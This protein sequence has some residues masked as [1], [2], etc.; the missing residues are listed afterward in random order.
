MLRFWISLWAAKATLWLFKKTGHERDDRPGLLA[1]KLCGRFLEKVH[2]PPL[3]IVVTGTNGKTTTS[4]LLNDLLTR[5]GKTVAYNTWGANYQAGQARCLLDAVDVFNR[6]VKDAAV[7]EADEL[8]TH[9]TLPWIRPNYLVVT[10]IERDSVRR[11]AHQEYIFRRIRRGIAEVPDTVLVLNADDPIG[12]FLA[13]GFGGA[14]KP[15]P[16]RRI[17]FGIA[18]QHLPHGDAVSPDFPVCP[19]C[20]T[21]PVFAYRHYRDIGVFSCP[22]CSLHSHTPDYLGDSLDFSARAM[23]VREPG[24]EIRRYPLLSGTVF[25]AF[26]VLAAVALLRDFGLS[27]AFL[28]Q[29]LSD[30][31]LP[32]SRSYAETCG[33]ITLHLQAAKGQNVSAASTVFEAISR[34]PSP[35]TL[36][37][38]MDEYYGYNHSVETVTWL[39]E[40]DFEYLNRES[41]RQI[42]AVGPRCLDHRLRLLLAGVP[43]EKIV[44]AFDE[45]GLPRT[46]Q[47]EGIKDI[48]ILCE[49]DNVAPARALFAA[50]S[51][52][53]REKEA[54]V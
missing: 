34:D 28:S 45:R 39:Y 11:N 49:V 6:P 10:N 48:Y 38:L 31:R 30:I 52:A 20:G 1:M 23:E 47:T 29:T 35:K 8:M 15:L 7:V 51:Q 12:S 13:E 41:I 37:L 25:N 22:S 40:T 54:S 4:S 46:V 36:I 42:V 5:A 18:D 32:S 33:G 24:G 2:K 3:V 26:N 44:A 43:K 17:F 21:P 53:L 9:K 19:V 27:P 16:N 50:L 14:E